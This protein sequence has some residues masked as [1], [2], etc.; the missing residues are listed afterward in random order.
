MD[1]FII[2]VFG[3]VT[4]WMALR[5]LVQHRVKQ[6]KEVM[7]AA[8]ERDMPQ[9]VNITFTKEGDL[10]QVHNSETQEFLAQGT[11]RE[12]IVKILEDRYPKISFRA[13]SKNLNEVFNDAAQ[14]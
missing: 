3:F 2:F 14:K 9:E 5:T 11:T 10:I 1:Y 6:F 13:S 8:I 7:M 4:G 12:E